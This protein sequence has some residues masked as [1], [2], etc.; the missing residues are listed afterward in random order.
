[1]EEG[2][3]VL[4]EDSMLHFKLK[5]GQA[6]NIKDILPGYSVLVSE[7]LNVSEE[8]IYETVYSIDGGA[9]ESGNSAWVQDISSNGAAVDFVNTRVTGITISKSVHNET[10]MGRE[11]TFT[12][13]LL[14][15]DP[16]NPM[17]PKPEYKS[18]GG[19][20]EGSGATA[21]QNGTLE[22][23]DDFMLTFKLKHGQTITIRDVEVGYN[24]VVF[25]TEDTRYAPT[26]SVNGEA[27]QSGATTYPIPM[28]SD[29]IMTID[30]VNAFIIIVPMGITDEPW[31]LIML[32]LGAVT[33]I[34][35]GLGAVNYL[36]R[37]A[38]R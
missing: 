17:T 31:T 25:E 20:L 36:K 38:Y 13:L 10:N 1:M 2:T 3:L 9:V 22:L 4:D 21:P 8:S 14:S 24:V 18:V 37:R 5:H 7:T 33:F 12:M 34:V 6:I 26:Y 15:S 27:E 23:I 35:S 11:F 30:F 16:S 29:G 19:I 32:S 28:S